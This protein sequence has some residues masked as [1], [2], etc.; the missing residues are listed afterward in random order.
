[1]Q[2]L[3]ICK[4]P[5]LPF[6]VSFIFQQHPSESKTWTGFRLPWNKNAS[7]KMKS[8]YCH[9]TRRLSKNLLRILVFTLTHGDGC[10]KAGRWIL[11]LNCGLPSCCCSLRNYSYALLPPWQTRR[12]YNGILYPAGW[13]QRSH[14]RGGLAWLRE[15]V[16]TA[17]MQQRE[18]GNIYPPVDFLYLK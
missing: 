11:F 7:L 12:I 10:L 4:H 18:T 5:P 13:K 15:A 9:I 17:F 6:S 8:L 1:M 2:I 14:W 16:E 3:D